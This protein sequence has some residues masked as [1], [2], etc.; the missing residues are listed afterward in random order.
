[1]SVRVYVTTQ[2]VAQLRLLHI[3]N[4]SNIS[5]LTKPNQ[6]KSKLIK[7]NKPLLEVIKT[8]PFLLIQYIFSANFQLA[9]TKLTLCPTVSPKIWQSA[10]WSKKPALCHGSH[11]SDL[12][13]QLS[14]LC[15]QLS[16]L[17][18]HLKKCHF[19]NLLCLSCVISNHC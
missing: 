7:P 14:S 10:Q 19:C 9:G 16:G 8:K 3:S 12:F 17:G 1:M 6:I 2:T 11:L 13:S 5:N 18:S 15:C 4:I